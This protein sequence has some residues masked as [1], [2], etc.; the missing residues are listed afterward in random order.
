MPVL[1]LS[2]FRTVTTDYIL[3]S[4]L[5][6]PVVSLI[7]IIATIGNP[8][9][10]GILTIVSAVALAIAGFRF[11]RILTIVN[12]NQM[13]DAVITHVYYYRGRGT[14]CFEFFYHGEKF[15]AK[16]HVIKTRVTSGFKPGDKIHALVDWNDPRKALIADLY[17]DPREIL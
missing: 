10:I 8:L 11:I 1:K 9:L 17:T 5:A 6:F 7:V 4:C 15:F 13:V 12:E 2:I 16:L 14:I 3:Y